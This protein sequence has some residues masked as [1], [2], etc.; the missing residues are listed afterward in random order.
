M[1]T[2]ILLAT[3]ML[4]PLAFPDVFM[5]GEEPDAVQ[6]DDL[7]YSAVEDAL[8]FEDDDEDGPL[9]IDAFDVSKDIIVL[10]A[11]DDVFVAD[12]EEIEGDTVFTLSDGSQVILTG[13]TGVSD[14]VIEFEAP[15]EA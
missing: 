3:A 2:T 4:S 6:D 10:E 7:Q 9:V 12:Q 14:E 1:F 15:E 5:G 11:E 8:P 13:I